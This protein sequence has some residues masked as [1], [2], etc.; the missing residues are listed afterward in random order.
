MKS[1]WR[2]SLLVKRAGMQK[3]T[4]MINKVT[5]H[6]NHT[7]SMVEQEKEC[8]KTL[9]LQIIVTTHKAWQNRRRSVSE[10]KNTINR[11]LQYEQELQL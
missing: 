3:M 8:D 6:S 1:C 7:Q 10:E 4:C 2:R 5:D 11:M 9:K